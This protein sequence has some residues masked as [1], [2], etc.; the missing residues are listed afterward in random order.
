MIT[1]ET[2]RAYEEYK[3]DCYWEG[4]TPVSLHAWL[5]GEE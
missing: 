5:E 1:V 2:L 4:R 3:I